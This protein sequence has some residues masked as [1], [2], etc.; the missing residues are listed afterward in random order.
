[1]PR[2]QPKRGLERQCSRILRA[3]GRLLLDL[4]TPS[5]HAVHAGE[6]ISARKDGLDAS[7]RGIV[8]LEV[9]IFTEG[10]QL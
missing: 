5:E 4:I 10:A 8:F 2:M 3:N 9:G 7:G 1:M 6:I